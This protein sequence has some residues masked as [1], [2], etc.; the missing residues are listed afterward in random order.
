MTV[1]AL[2]APSRPRVGLGDLAIR[3]AAWALLACCL[4]LGLTILVAGEHEASMSELQSAIDSGDVTELSVEGTLRGGVAHWQVGLL[5]RVTEL[6]RRPR[7]RL[8]SEVEVIQTD[9][10][11]S[12]SQL[13]SWH[14]PSAAGLLGLF[15]G[16]GAFVL[17]VAG[18]PPWRA[19][20]WGWFWLL[21]AVPWLAIPGFLL[22][23]GPSG[24][25]PPRCPRR[26][27]S[28]GE[29]LM[30]GVVLAVASAVLVGLVL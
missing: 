16:L 9:G 2:G 4:L 28:G 30:L 6:E 3:G 25:L 22:F 1:E 5:P 18:P 7:L 20:R 17:L 19:S 10:P 23:A 27:I 26:R 12:W 11:R 14:L 24:L 29:G 15:P 8:T 13:G 21:L